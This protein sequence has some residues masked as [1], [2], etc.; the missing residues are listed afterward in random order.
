IAA[1]YVPP[2]DRIGYKFEVNSVA[3]ADDRICSYLQVLTFPTMDSVSDSVFFS[4]KSLNPIVLYDTELAHL[5]IYTEKVVLK[6]IVNNRYIVLIV[7][8][9]STWICQ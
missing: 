1:R 6:N 2:N 5:Y 9:N 7:N 4:S 8:L 3:M